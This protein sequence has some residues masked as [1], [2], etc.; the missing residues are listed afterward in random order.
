MLSLVV[1]NG[2]PYGSTTT[3]GVYLYNHISRAD[4]GTGAANSFLLVIAVMV[5][6]LL[7]VRVLR[8]KD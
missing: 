6:S 5:L 2:G 3:A 4:L 8:P 7:F 1:T